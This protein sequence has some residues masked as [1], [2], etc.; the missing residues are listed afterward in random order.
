M[1]IAFISKDMRPKS[2]VMKQ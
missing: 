1:N 2:S